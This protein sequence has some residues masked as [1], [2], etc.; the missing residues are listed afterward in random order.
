M[1]ILCI[2]T[3][4]ICRSPMMEYF[5][6]NALAEQFPKAAVFSAGL[7]TDDGYT[8]TPHAVA[9]MNEIGVDISGHRSRQL[10]QAIAD[11]T[12]AFVAMTTEHGVTLAFHYG[13]DPK[14]IIV[15]GAGV[16]DPY[17]QD[18]ATYRTCRDLLQASLPQVIEELQ[19]L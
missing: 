7:A 18:L 11:N 10:T 4:N 12:D 15:P 19:A 2:C 17:G 16:P 6:K 9:A 14:K 3:G 8:P 5:L 13:V 1:N